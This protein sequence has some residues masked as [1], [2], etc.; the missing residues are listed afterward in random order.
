[1]LLGRMLRNSSLD[2]TLL[3]GVYYLIFTQ[4]VI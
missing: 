4:L 3:T 2:I 1:M